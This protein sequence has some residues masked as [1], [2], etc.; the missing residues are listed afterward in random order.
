MFGNVRL[1]VALAL[2]RPCYSGS[3]KEGCYASDES[4][5]KG[6]NPAETYNQYFVPAMFAPWA[7]VL[8]DSAVPARGEHVLDVACGTGIVAR[9][10]APLVGASGAVTGLDI[11]AAMLAV[12]RAVPAPSG[13]AITW[14]EGV[15]SRYPSPTTS[16]DLVVCQQGL[17]FFP[18]RAVA[19]QEMRRVLKRGGRVAISVNQSLHANPMYE[20]LFEALARHLGTTVDVIAQPYALGDADVLHDLLLTAGFDQIELTPIVVP[21]RFP[22]TR[23]IRS[24]RGRIV[25]SGRSGIC[26]Q[27]CGSTEHDDRSDHDRASADGPSIHRWG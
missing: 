6:D 2:V 16:F 26:E 20:A 18:D 24:T 5:G 25:G 4:S 17:Q 27:R 11:N 13:A 10:V 23:T 9:E 15:R 1:D 3:I 22:A 8:L 12:A 7:T 21:V 14:Q 19:L